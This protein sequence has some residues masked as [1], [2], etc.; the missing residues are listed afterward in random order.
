V[1]LKIVLKEETPSKGNVRESPN[2]VLLISYNVTPAELNV[3]RAFSISGAGSLVL[4]NGALARN[5]FV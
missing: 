2:F 1:Q 5:L 4:W 3:A